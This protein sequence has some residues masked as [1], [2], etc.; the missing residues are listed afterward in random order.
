ML[1]WRL[2]LG[3]LFIALLVGLCWLDARSDTAGIW[4]LPLALLLSL[5]AT[6]ETLD[7]LTVDGVRPQ[8]LVAYGGNFLIVGS[9]ALPLL[10]VE[11]LPSQ[12]WPFVTLGVVLFIA[13]AV[14]VFRYAPQQQ[15]TLRLALTSLAIVYVGVCLSS[16]VQLRLLGSGMGL[17][18][19]AALILVVKLSDTGAYTVGRLVGRTKLAP[20]LS[21]GKTI[22][23]SLGGLAA[24]VLGALAAFYWVLPSLAE[25]NYQLAA[26]TWLWFGLSVGIAGMIGDLA[27]SLLK[28]EAGCKDS[29]RW[30]PGFGGVL[31]L[32]DSILLGAPVAYLA[33]VLCVR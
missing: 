31:D 33:W 8:S 15:A 5:A 23:G 26:G 30:M 24:G 7:L 2:T 20:R 18:A 9:N 11:M 12:A 3:A 25:R 19:L 29:S 27:E 10:G 4:L 1:R 21:P 22:E 28:R 14:E 17:A 6:Q 16:V 13:F 32:L